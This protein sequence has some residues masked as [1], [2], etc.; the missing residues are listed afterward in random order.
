MRL[1]QVRVVQ[2]FE[3]ALAGMASN[4]ID[5]ESSRMNR[6]FGGTLDPVVSGSS[7][8]TKLALAGHASIVAKNAIAAA[9]IG[10]GAYDTGRPIA[11]DLLLVVFFMFKSQGPGFD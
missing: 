11:C 1:Q 2:V 3:T 6:I 8:I 4:A 10:A 7:G 9:R 5:P